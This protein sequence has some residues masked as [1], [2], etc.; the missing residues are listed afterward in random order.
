MGKSADHQEIEN[1]DTEY[2]NWEVFQLRSG[3]ACSLY[4]KTTE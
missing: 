4:G 2:S 1:L 3:W